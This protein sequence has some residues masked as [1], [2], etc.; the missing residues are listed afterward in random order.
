M[1][2]F[3][4][5]SATHMLGDGADQF[6]VGKAGI[7]TFNELTKELVRR[8]CEAEC[9]S[10]REHQQTD[11]S[12]L[13]KSGKPKSR[14]L[15][16]LV[17]VMDKDRFEAFVGGLGLP[18]A[19]SKAIN[20]EYKAFAKKLKIV[21]DLAAARAADQE[22]RDEDAINALAS[23]LGLEEGK[24]YSFAAKCGLNEPV[25]LSKLQT[26]TEKYIFSA[27][28]DYVENS[29]GDEDAG[30]SS[31]SGEDENEVVVMS[32]S[33]AFKSGLTRSH[34]NLKDIKKY[35]NA[36]PEGI[37]DVAGYW[38]ENLEDY[39]PPP[40]QSTGL[41]FGWSKKSEQEFFSHLSLVLEV[42]VAHVLKKTTSKAKKNPVTRKVRGGEESTKF[43]FENEWFE[44]EIKKLG[45]EGITSRDPELVSLVD[46]IMYSRRLDDVSL[47]QLLQ[48]A[49]GVF[50]K[51]AKLPG[52]KKRGPCVVAHLL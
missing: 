49:E 26:E 8:F 43:T 13:T 14:K 29:S 15:K 32:I 9:W 33:D 7:S 37:E 21:K 44:D 3:T 51:R 50:M 16:S 27:Y 39:S 18:G 38:K 24:K 1:S 52:E 25:S 6:S 30:P 4:S 36:V 5:S 46:L 40:T 41:T 17:G 31:N 48:Q 12:S 34:N 35:Y 11:Y 2:L 23:K 45:F 10:I 42:I 20:K 28:C 47:D 19:V 22:S